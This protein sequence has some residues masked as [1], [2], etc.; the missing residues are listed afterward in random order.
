MLSSRIPLFNLKNLIILKFGRQADF[1][2]TMGEHETAVSA[3]I[4]RRRKLSPEK[5]AAWA[6]ALGVQ[7]G[8]V[9]GNE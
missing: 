8:E 2:Y 6:K 5:K 7:V 3:V 4:R 9:F 1:A